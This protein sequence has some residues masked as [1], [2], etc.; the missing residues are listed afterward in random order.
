MNISEESGVEYADIIKVSHQK[1]IVFNTNP[2]WII[3]L[4]RLAES[5]SEL[6]K[7][8]VS[9]LEKTLVSIITP[10]FNGEA[11]LDRYFS[12]IL[13]QTYS[14]IE[15]IF[16]NDG[17]LDRTAEIVEKYRPALEK[18]GICFTYLYQE[19]AGQAAALNL[20]LKHFKGEYLTWPDA[21][22]EMTPDCIEKK[23][24]FL[25]AHPELDMC[26]CKVL[27]VD[28]CDNSRELGILERRIPEGKDNLFE[29]LLC[30]RNVFYTPGGYMVRSS[31]LDESV[32][33]RDIYTGHGG[34]NVQLLLPIS[35]RKK[36]GYIDDVLYRYF[37][38]M[39][40]HSHSIDTAEKELHQYELFETLLIETLRRMPEGICE[41][42]EDDIRSRYSRV[43]FGI[44]L[45]TQQ[46]RLICQYYRE[47][48]K[49]GAACFI[50]W[51]RFI[52]HSNPLTT[53]R[54]GI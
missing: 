41:R 37:V 30:L 10:C 13:N 34:Q 1:M 22:D 16:V 19:N 15:L 25:C 7:K 5:W 36:Y 54:K 51:L 47:L 39:D 35:Y 49:V 42:Y 6:I 48:K 21:D 17:S 14:P 18:K 3:I 8:L 24:A 43:R 32:P 45:N 4:I 52:K 27:Q 46:P 31:A 11:Y 50:D 33:K 28:E 2:K 40:S 44:A 9:I 53:K 26:I 38:R 20:G 23:V 12:S 29:D